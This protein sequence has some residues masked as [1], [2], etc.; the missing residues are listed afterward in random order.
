M[1]AAKRSHPEEVAK[2]VSSKEKTERKTQ[3]SADKKERR[4]EREAQGGEDDIDAILA[5]LALE[6]A[7]KSIEGLADIKVQE[8]MRQA[9]QAI[10]AALVAL[11]GPTPEPSDE[12]QADAYAKAN[13]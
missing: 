1:E 5:S 7:K 13:D 3:K 6:D 4:K 8:R 10:V 9:E 12:E 11:D 2:K